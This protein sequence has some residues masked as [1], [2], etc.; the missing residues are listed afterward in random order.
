LVDDSR[1]GLAAAWGD[2][3]SVVLE[4]NAGKA[5]TARLGLV[6]FDVSQVRGVFWQLP[7][8]SNAR[9]RVVNE[10]MAT[11]AKKAKLDSLLLD[12][13]DVLVGKLIKTGASI[14]FE[15]IVGY[16]NLPIDRVRGIVLARKT[17]ARK[18]AEFAANS[19]MLVGLREGSVIV[20][21]SIRRNEKELVLH[22]DSLGE[23][24]V[25]DVKEIAS[26][27]SFGDHVAYLSDLKAASFRH[28]PY[29][30]LPWP[31]RRDRNVVNGPLVVVGRQFLKGL[32]VHS[33]SRLTFPL[34]GQHDRFATTV[35]IDDAA[36]GQGSVVFRV[37]LHVDNRWREA[38]ES[39]VVR[40]GDPPL[41]IAVE[42]GQANQLALEVEYADRGDELDYADW[43]DARLERTRGAKSP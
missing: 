29:L 15:G 13:D 12:N 41:E 21:E 20:A 37:L 7:T 32:G 8:D 14:G 34:D 4:G 24:R 17:A 23:V 25:G 2:Q 42:L 28:E 19:K 22:S 1:L 10:L 6:K 26:L 33:K 9:Q 18:N 3:P 39:P 38:F 43:L 40:G 11:Q 16:V 5:R 36:E 31:Y 27:Q 30:D 35:A